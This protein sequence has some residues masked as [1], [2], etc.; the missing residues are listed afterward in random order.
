[1]NI[2]QWTLRIRI[3]GLSMCLLASDIGID[4]SD[5]ACFAELAQYDAAESGLRERR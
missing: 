4:S 5:K 1:V 3:E 2:P